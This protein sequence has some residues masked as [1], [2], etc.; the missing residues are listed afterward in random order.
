MRTD[1]NTIRPGF[2]LIE[3]LVVIAIIA[4]LVALLLPAVQQAREAARRSQCKNNLKQ[5]GLAL[6][7]Y[8]DTHN[9]FPYRRGGTGGSGWT[10]IERLCGTVSLLPQIEQTT[11]YNQITNSTSP[12]NTIMAMGPAPWYSTTIAYRPTGPAQFPAWAVQISM[13]LCPSAPP[14]PSTS[15]EAKKSYH[16][17][18]GDGFSDQNSDKPRGMFGFRSSTRMRDITDGTSN[19]IAIAERAFAVSGRTSIGAIATTSLPSSASPAD[20]AA[21]WNG[22][23]Q[24]YTGNFTADWNGNRWADGNPSFSAVN[25][26]LPPNSASCTIESGNLQGDNQIGFYSVSSHHTGGAHILLADGAVRFVSENIN[27]GDQTVAPATQGQS[28]YGVWGA[29][30]TKGS[31]EVTGEF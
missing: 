15:R 2:T 29:L 9:T 23:S 20:C 31:G 18:N 30:G 28:N 24:G 5:F 26:A 13:L 10:N 27:S 14:H 16:F 12:D 7:N 4:I 3:L 8:H 19:T 6:H 22:P 1:K 17:C 21:L 25:T 11:L